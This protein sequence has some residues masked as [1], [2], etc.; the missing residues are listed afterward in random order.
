MHGVRFIG[1]VDLTHF[2]Q[3]SYDRPTSVQ[4]QVT[5]HRSV[6]PSFKP[7]QTIAH[8]SRRARVQA[9]DAQA[10]NIRMNIQGKHLEVRTVPTPGGLSSRGL[11]HELIPGRRSPNARRQAELL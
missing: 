4:L 3:R 6:L 5:A 9:V 7:L 2:E 8:T 1:H 11:A 10:S